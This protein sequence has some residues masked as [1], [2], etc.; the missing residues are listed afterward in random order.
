MNFTKKEYNGQVSYEAQIQAE[1]IS[2]SET[3]MQN[4][5]GTKYRL[6]Q[7]EFDNANS[8]RVIRNGIIYEANYNHPQ[9]DWKVG[10]S[11]LTTVTITEGR[12]D[13]LIKVSHLQQAVR[14][15]ATNDF[16]FDVSSASFDA[17][18]SDMKA[19]GEEIL[20]EEDVVVSSETADSLV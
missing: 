12:E 13:A 19:E 16:G 20:N 7:V 5:N 2:I 9:A 10:A 15:S 18:T 4:V 8:E 6:C 17:A 11:Y 1:L 3:E 14:A